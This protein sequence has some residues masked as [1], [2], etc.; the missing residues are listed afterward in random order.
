[1]AI[2]ETM[3]SRRAGAWNAR[4][5]LCA[6]LLADM[7]L[8]L[9]PA[10]KAGTAARRPEDIKGPPP[11][12]KQTQFAYYFPDGSVIRIKPAGDEFNGWQPSF[13]VE[14]KNAGAPVGPSDPSMIAFKVDHLG[15]AVPKG[16][17]TSRIPTLMGNSSAN[18]P[19]MISMFSTQDIG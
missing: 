17:T 13:S 8:V 16:Q 2:H 10:V 18:A 3:I 4:H 12:G 5:T 7:E 9:E 19:S 15:R 1:M 11:T 6:M 14:L